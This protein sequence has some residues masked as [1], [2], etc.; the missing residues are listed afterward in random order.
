MTRA[1]LTERDD[2]LSFGRLS[3]QGASCCK[4]EYLDEGGAN[5]I[6]TISGVKGQETP[7]RV[8]HRLLRLRKEV[9][10]GVVVSAARQLQNYQEH[11][12]PLFPA[13]NQLHYEL[14]TLS[15]AL[16]E[17][18][19]DDVG[20]MGDRPANRITDMIA[21]DNNGTLITDMRAGDGEVLL[22]LKPKWLAQSPTA[23]AASRRCRTCALRAKRTSVRT[24]TATDAQE[25]CPLDFI[26]DDEDRRLDAARKLAAQQPDLQQYL[27]NDAQP[28]LKTLKQHQLA[29]DP[30]GA[31][32]V[33]SVEDTLALTKAMTLRDCTLFMRRRVDGS[34]E[35]RLGDLDMKAPGKMERWADVERGLIDGGWYADEGNEER[36]CALS[37]G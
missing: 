34:V 10:V 30:H 13:E 9:Y 21:E 6:F 32:K 20:I 1:Y 33:L 29:L 15:D 11:F 22:Q 19:D 35:A 36:V 28:L 37:R 27:V 16:V 17:A 4:L 3:Q 14:V 31:M 24:R 5:F 2:K 18:L 23:P 25:S 12:A 26:A 8:Q 7:K